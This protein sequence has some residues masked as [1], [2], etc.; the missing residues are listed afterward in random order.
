MK[1]EFSLK[2]SPTEHILLED[3]VSYIQTKNECIIFTVEG[4]DTIL[5]EDDIEDFS[6]YG[7]GS[8]EEDIK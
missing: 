8:E 2:R 5:R 7:L 6:V 4:L 1:I 3:V